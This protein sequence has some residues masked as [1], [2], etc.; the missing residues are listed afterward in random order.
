MD[1]GQKHAGM[2]VCCIAIDAHL[3]GVRTGKTST[4]LTASFAILFFSRPRHFHKLLF[5]SV[6][7]CGY[8]FVSLISKEIY[9]QLHV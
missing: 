4:P 3:S 7:I 5:L 8:L 1:T 2:T 6:F 9:D